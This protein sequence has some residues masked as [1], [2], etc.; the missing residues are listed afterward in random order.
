MEQFFF[1]FIKEFIIL[2]QLLI[3]MLLGAVIGIDREI[4]GKPAGV[5]TLMIVSGVSTLFVRLSLELVSNFHGQVKDAFLAD[6][7]RVTVAIVTGIS[8]IGAG[9]IIRS[10][11]HEKVEGVTTAATLLL[12][13]SIG[14]SVGLSMYVLAVGI[15]V[16]SVIILFLFKKLELLFDVNKNEDI[17][18]E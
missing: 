18:E 15:A 11:E 17:G 10:R 1:F 6:P 12:A 14:I 5:R 9:S 3:S 13:A 4:S 2:G 7:I 8:F 16:L